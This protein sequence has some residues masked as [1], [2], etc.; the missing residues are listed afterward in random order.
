MEGNSLFLL[1][2][3]EL[4]LK[5]GNKA[6]FE[7]VLR[8][9]L[10]AMLR[11]SGAQINTA[12]GRIYVKCRAQSESIV[13]NV[14]KHLSGITGW[15]KA[16]KVEK[17]IDAV[18]G[19]ILAEAGECF[20]RGMRSFKIEARRTDKSF[21]FD[22]YKICCMGGDAVKKY[23]PQF[24]IKLQKPDVTISVEIR[25]RAY[26]YGHV[27]QGLRGLPVGTA[28]RGLLL[29]SGGID[30]PVAGFMMSMRGMCLEA[31]YFH[32]YPYTSD[33]ARQKVV[34]LAGII[35]AYS[36]GVRL[37]TIQFT[38]VQQRI[39]ESAPED[40]S[41]VLLRMAMMECASY[42]AKMRRCK[43]LITGESL[44]QVA[45]QTVEN[46]NCSESK[47]SYPVLRPLIGMDKESIIKTACAIGTYETSILPYQDCCV[48]FSP[49]HPV[50]HGDLKLASELYSSLA[51][52]DLIKEAV[53]GRTVEKLGCPPE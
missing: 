48:L 24:N 22:S 13:E 30:S 7:R 34:R 42:L 17:N 53:A 44:S 38:K 47:A 25:E 3:G 39:K 41:T 11:G 52:H 5:G 49:Q 31:V 10:A 18:L 26:I 21:P 20:N 46:I 1:K 28:A 37:H 15:S 19:A 4:S 40:W 33:E 14:L 9:N 35:G 51:I 8:Q 43:C 2:L 12:S 6:Y 29:L 23:F 45:S 27:N 16:R 32:A 50:L 36:M